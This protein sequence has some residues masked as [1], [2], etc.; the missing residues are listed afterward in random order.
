ML[1]IWLTNW[2]TRSLTSMLAYS[3]VVRLCAAMQC[4]SY[5]TFAAWIIFL[6][7]YGRCNNINN[8]QTEFNFRWL[9]L[10]DITCSLLWVRICEKV[11]TIEGPVMAAVAVN[12]IDDYHC[13]FFVFLWSSH[14][15]TKLWYIDVRSAMMCLLFIEQCICVRE[16]WM[17]R[18][19]HAGGSSGTEWGSGYKRNIKIKK[20][21]TTTTLIIRME[22]KKWINKAFSHGNLSQ[23]NKIKRS[24]TSND[25]FFHQLFWSVSPFVSFRRNNERTIWTCLW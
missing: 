25:F 1:W 17:G 7:L 20:E 18:T 22:K 8:N 16:Q 11:A 14:R 19:G 21:S 9:R 15:F 13:L 4:E 6:S 5:N 12:I 23:S 24:H 2:F 10:S 3:F